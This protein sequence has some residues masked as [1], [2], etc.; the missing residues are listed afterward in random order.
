MKNL[1]KLLL[2]LLIAVGYTSCTEEFDEINTDPKAITLDKLDLSNYG[3]IVRKAIISPIYCAHINGS[4]GMQLIQSLHFDVYSNY[5]ATTTPNFLSDRNVMVGS[6]QNGMFNAFYAGEAAQIKYMEDFARQENLKGE[7]A[8][9]KIWKVYIY[10][11]YTDLLGP[12][13]YSQYGNMQKTVPYDKQSDVYK[14]FFL[15]LDSAVAILKQNAGGTSAVITS[16][17]PIYKGKYDNWQKMANTLRLRLGMRI[18]YVDAATAKTQCEKA[19]AD[20]VMTTNAES[21]WY[22]T[23]TTFPNPYNTIS[24]WGEYR[25]SADMES[26]CKG[27][28][29]KRITTRFSPA[30]T[31]DNTDDT[32]GVAFPYEGLLNGQTKNDRT[33]VSYNTL[34][35]DHQPGYLKVGDKG[36]NWHI[37]RAPEAYFLRAEGAVLGWNMGAGT[38]QSFYEEGIKLSLAENGLDNLNMANEDYVTSTRVPAS[39]GID[40]NTVR[41]NIATVPV[42]TV[43]VKWDAAASQEVQLEQISTQKWLALFPDSE[44]AYAERRRTGYPK[45]LPRVE[46]ENPDV[47]REKVPYRALY[48]TVEYTNNK[49]EVEKAIGLLNA[50]SS[51]A[52]GDKASTKLWWDKKPGI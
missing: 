20:G 24:S 30:K 18:R 4:N 31:P 6:W 23:T 1:I 48:Y 29:D 21:G 36:P 50:E 7:L 5:W 11:R 12:I 47:P 40:K 2:V 39:P 43:P 15:E 8:V 14:S 51:A 46:S 49:A 28:L 37:M 25:M 3:F 17:D 38:A 41:P 32:E 44:E 52:N 22:T 33:A 26:I 9:A 13:V 27:Y 42:S 45:L 10:L 19:V 16:F 34:M 35:S